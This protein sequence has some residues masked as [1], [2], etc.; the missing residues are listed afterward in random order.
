LRVLRGTYTG[1]QPAATGPGTIS[2]ERNVPQ[3]GYDSTRFATRREATPE[4]DR[5]RPQAAAQPLKGRSS[6]NNRN[7]IAIVAAVVVVIGVIIW[8]NSG[9]EELAMEEQRSE[10]AEATRASD[11]QET[12]ARDEAARD[13]QEATVGRDETTVD[14]DTAQS[15][16]GTGTDSQAGAG[17][18]DV[19][20]ASGHDP[21]DLLTPE[22]FE[23]EE[24]LA[25]I[26][27]SEELSDERR[28]TLRALVERAS[29]D[30]EMVDEA[31][32]SIRVAL[33]L[34]PLN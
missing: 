10:Q 33:D 24:V 31:I 27:E 25:L 11:E 13:A 1:R 29:D 15:D 4:I 17:G 2:L 28:S 6:M 22:N 8:I 23:R 16:A 14:T 3:K 34:P 30:P 21:A 26:D 20:A 12:V 9:S 32:N 19:D 7:I 18:S 5:T